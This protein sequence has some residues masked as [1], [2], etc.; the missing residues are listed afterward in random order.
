MAETQIPSRQIADGAITNAKVAAGAAIATSKLAGGADFIVRTG[1]VPMTGA[2]DM[3]SQLITNVATPSTGTDAANRSYVDTLIASTRNLFDTKQSVRAMAIVNVNVA[4]PGTAVFD[5]VTLTNGQRLALSAQSA[6]AENGI[7]IFAT[8]GTPLTRAEDMD[9]W[10]EVI[11]A[12]FAVEEGTTRADT[13]W[14]ATPDVGGTLGTTAITFQQIGASSG[15]LSSNFV[16]NE[17]PAGSVNGSNTVFTLANTPVAGTVQVYL[18]GLL[19]DVG[20]GNDYTISGTSITFGTAPLTGEKVRV[21][22]IK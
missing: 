9:I 2:L 17:T 5:G 7:Y 15:L 1:A 22:Y 14:L 3:G 18:N 21:H 13:V 8:S 16:T 20:G 12:L 4:N 10:D 19:Q 6:P 11:G